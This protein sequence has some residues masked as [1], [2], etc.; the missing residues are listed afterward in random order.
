M[1]KFLIII[2]IVLLTGCLNS[3]NRGKPEK[4]EKSEPC[5]DFDYDGDN[6]SYDEER[7]RGTDPCLWDSDNDTISDWDEIFKEFTDPLSNDTDNDTLLDAID[8]D[9]LSSENDEDLD[10][11][12]DQFDIDMWV[13]V[14][15]NVSIEWTWNASDDENF[16]LIFYIF[17]DNV[18]E[19]ST[20]G[21]RSE[22]HIIDYN[23]PDDRTYLNC[24]LGGGENGYD[25]W[26]YYQGYEMNYSWIHSE[27]AG[28]LDFE[29]W[30][31]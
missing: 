16:Q 24:S 25:N 27:P 31:D 28:E 7:N 22:F 2:L 8:P 13:D 17:N 6:L 10:G 11:V 15:Y 30:L 21:D 23:W 26:Y 4:D 29:F 18:H 12:L 20:N 14:H 3:L 1:K 9:P 5:S 19:R